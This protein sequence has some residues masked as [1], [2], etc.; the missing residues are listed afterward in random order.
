MYL[1]RKSKIALAIAIA[2]GC[3]ICISNKN[4]YAEEPIKE[5]NS[6]LLDSIT[7]E[8]K[9][10]D[11]ETKLSPGSVTVVRPDDYKGEQKSLPDLLREVPGVHVR[12]VN[13]KGQYTT[14]TVRGSTAAQVGVFIDGVLSNLGGDA[15]VD[16]STIPIKNVERVEVYRGYIPSRFPG[17]FMGG[18]INIVTKRPDKANVSAEL[19]RASYGGMDASLQITAPVGSGSLMV[20][21]NHEA[22][23]G[24]FKYDNFMSKVKAKNLEKNIN[25]IQNIN[26]NLH[27]YLIDDL[28][29]ADQISL[30]PEEVEGFINDKDSWLE[31]VYDEG[32]HGLAQEVKNGYASEVANKQ[33]GEFKDILEAKGYKDA[34]IATGYFNEYNWLE[35]AEMDWKSPVMGFD[36]IKAEDKAEVINEYVDKNIGDRVVAVQNKADPNKNSEFTDNEK[37]IQADKKQLQEAENSARWRKYN[38]YKKSSSIVKWQNDNW[39]IKGSW[40]KTDRHLPDGLWGSDDASLADNFYNVDLYDTYRYDSRHQ[41]VET[42]DLM[43][44]NRNEVGKLEWGWLVDYTHQ[45]KDYNAEHLLDISETE[46]S[47]TPLVEWSKYKSNKYNGQ[48]DGTYKLS[49]NNMLDFQMNYA[50][51]K[52]DIDGSKM[53]EVLD[54]MYEDM[55][56]GQMRNKYE[57]EVFNV[58]LQDSIT[59]DKEGTWMLTPSVRYNQSKITGISNGKRFQEGQFDWITPKDSETNGKATWQLAM[60][61]DFND[62][63]TMRMTGGTYYR[64][65]NMYE[66]A[67]DGAGI[68]PAPRKEG[69]GSIFP[70][71]ESGKQFDVSAI[72]NGRALGADNRS[73]LTYFWRDSENMLQLVR[74]GLYHWCYFNDNKGTSKGIELESEFNWNKFSLDL[75]A[76]YTDSKMQRKNSAV[77]YDYADVWATY[78]PEWEGNIRLNYSP[79]DTLSFFTEAHFVDEYFTSD[80]RDTTNAEMDY[81]AGKPVSSLWVVNGGMKLKLKNKWQLSFGC[82]DIFNEGPKQKIT[83]TTLFNGIAYLNPEF[84]I[85]GRTYYATVRYDF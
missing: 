26:D 20:G 35:G 75:Q 46:S 8:A 23:D 32:E 38:D 76:T 36:I 69:L 40:N 13:G 73:T 27:K 64:L 3:S 9:R 25:K 55:L 33:V 80:A 65:L 68:L 16:I 41:D 21:I 61:K 14:V 5:E 15:A 63:F 78:Q 19:G 62:N 82:N 84:P 39:M 29:N 10:P 60:K 49:D 70:K 42:A 56:A 24:D 43:I 47:W 52:M 72:W 77:N 53:D 22:S 81:L 4:I 11:W 1:R 6:F 79:T 28:I 34:Y 74:A 83:S 71:P 59:L 30:T 54:G 17:T 37:Q 57:Q 58:Q 50:Y 67:G 18:V 51:E 12:E 85:Q 45:D 66:I 31:Y 48:I 2:L 44:Q 7:V